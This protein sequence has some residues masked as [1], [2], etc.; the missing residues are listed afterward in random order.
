MI[1]GGG[2]PNATAATE[3]IEFSKPTPAWVRMGDMPSGAR[4]DGNSVLLPNGKLLAQG[5]SRVH[6]DPTTATLGADLFDPA[7]GTWSSTNPGGAGFAT[8]PRLYHWV[9]LLLPDATV[10]TTG[11]ESEK[12][13]VGWTY[14]DLLTCLLI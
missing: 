6:N 12:Q 4:V 5:G 13:H 10:A 2:L 1:L 3:I 7:T 8:Y 14:R 9:A 11:F